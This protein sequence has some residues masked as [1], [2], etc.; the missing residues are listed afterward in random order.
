MTWGHG[1]WRKLNSKTQ[2]EFPKFIM[3]S[4]ICCF[5]CLSGL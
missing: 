1:E 2:L 3:Q 5:V 4:D